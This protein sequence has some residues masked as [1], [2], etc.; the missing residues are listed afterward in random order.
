MGKRSLYIIIVGFIMISII[1]CK[2]YN[3]VQYAEFYQKCP[4]DT[5][6]LYFVSNP[7]LFRKL[8]SICEAKHEEFWDEKVCYVEFIANRDEII[9]H[10][11]SCLKPLGI[12]YYPIYFRPGV[13]FFDGKLIYVD[14]YFIDNDIF[15]SMN[16]DT[17]LASTQT[18]H[19]SETNCYFDSLYNFKKAEKFESI[20]VD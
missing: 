6:E 1:S 5:F 20:Y 17:I 15:S 13:A 9:M 4:K 12:N 2:S 8:L 10:L 7:N 11:S 19:F 3:E 16:K 14:K 18:A